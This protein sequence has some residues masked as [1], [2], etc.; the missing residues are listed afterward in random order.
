MCPRVDHPG[1]PLPGPSSFFLGGL[2][3]GSSR[4]F[5][6]FPGVLTYFQTISLRITSWC[7]LL[8]Q[9]QMKPLCCQTCSPPRAEVAVAPS[10]LSLNRATFIPRDA[11]A[12]EP[13]ARRD[14]RLV[15][16][17]LL[18]ASWSPPAVWWPGHEVR[19]STSPGF[20]ATLYVPFVALNLRHPPPRPETPPAE[21]HRSFPL[22]IRTSNGCRTTSWLSAAALT[23]RRYRRELPYEPI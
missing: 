18:G 21:T 4:I 19:S 13:R 22:L 1:G 6:P 16:R 23:C 15:L 3:R 2:C 14:G 11:E 8:I 17:H 9:T 7:S 20:K 12:A 5:A 10:F